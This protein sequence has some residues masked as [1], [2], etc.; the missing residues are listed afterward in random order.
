MS[1][2]RFYER[3]FNMPYFN[4]FSLQNEEKYFKEYFIKSELCITGFSHGAQKAFEHVFK[5]EE[6]VDR[7]ILLSPRIL[8][9]RKVFFP[10]FTVTLF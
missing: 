4:G 7:L 8:S 5:S 3:Y 2:K 10:S 9:D 1:V 6:R